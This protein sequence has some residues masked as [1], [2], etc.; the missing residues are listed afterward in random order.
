MGRPE[1]TLPVREL[2][3]ALLARQMLLERRRLAPMAAVERLVALQAQ[4]P[5]DPYVALWSRL[6]GFRPSVLSDAVESRRAVRMTLLRATLHL[7][8]SRD[9]LALRPAFQPVVERMFFG[10]RAFRGA[11]A[12]VDLGEVVEAFRGALEQRPGTRSDLSRVVAERWP[13]RDAENLGYAMYLL[14]TVQVTPRGLWGRSGR[15]AVTTLEHWLGAPRL[16]PD[17]GTGRTGLVRRYL[18]VF[19]PATPADFASWSGLAGMRES[20][21]ELRPRLRTFRDERGR[22]LFDVPRGPLPDPGIPAPVRFLP[23]YDNVLLG[24]EDRSRIVPEGV[25]QWTEVGWGGVLVDGF[26]S[27]RWRATP[28]ELLV[29]PFRRLAREERRQLAEEAHR[30]A[31]FLGMPTSPV[32]IGAPRTAPPN[33]RPGHQPNRG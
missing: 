25:R 28:D 17:D 15:A 31:A 12:G 3:R 24:H 13:D 26:L 10:Q 21:E 29:E 2:N 33:R 23:E 11:A 14:P 30:L 1:R 8:S 27:A 4:V 18:A 9:A 32:R 20:F 19:G 5:R 7:V 6:E 16:G 22:E